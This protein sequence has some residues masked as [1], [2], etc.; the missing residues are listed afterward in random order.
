MTH[1][2]SEINAINKVTE[3][4]FN[5]RKDIV[6]V[7]AHDANDNWVMSVSCSSDVYLEHFEFNQGYCDNIEQIRK[8]LLSVI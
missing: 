3:I 1:T 4:V 7:S 8:F 6:E 5:Y 2:Q